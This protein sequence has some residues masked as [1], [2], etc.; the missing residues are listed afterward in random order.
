MSYAKSGNTHIYYERRGQGPAVVFCHGAGSNAATWWQQLPT[1]ARR[2]TCITI[3]NRGFGRS[4]APASGFRLD[5]FADDVL[6]VMDAEGIDSAALICHSLGGMTGLRLALREPQRV[7]AFAC[8]DSPMAI[9]HAQML[10][11]VRG[12]FLSVELGN[13]ENSALSP[14]FVQRHPELAVLYRQINQ[15]N[16]SI[17]NEEASAGLSARLASLLQLDQLLPLEVLEVLGCPT[18]LLVGSEDP[19]VTPAVVRDV[20][21]HIPGSRVV[22]IEGAGHSPY[23]EQPLRFN[24]EVLSFLEEAAQALPA[25][26]PMARRTG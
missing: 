17:F 5:V 23:F 7:W 24:T 14:G 26:H 3:D 16:P 6:A 22:E 11:N 25:A 4:V 1:F 19:I 18:L 13:L 20:A 2:Y 12:F 21:R 8:C 9:R 10:A 15:F